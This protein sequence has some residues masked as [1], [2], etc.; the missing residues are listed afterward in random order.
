MNP[1][2]VAAILTAAGA[3][4]RMGESKALLD[5]GELPLLQHQVEV[6]L[7]AG[8][9]D[10]VVVLGD[11]A[12][13]IEAAVR[14]PARVRRIRNSRVD[15]GRSESLR[16]GFEA[17]QDQPEAIL[18]V[19]VDQP[20]SGDVLSKLLAAFDPERE[21]FAQPSFSGL[22]SHPVLFAG[23]LLAELQRIDEATRGLRAVTRRHASERLDVTLEGVPSPEFNTPAEYRA[24]IA[25][26]PPGSRLL[27]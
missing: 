18:V 22:R 25:L 7:Q 19:A 27:P 6:L 23:R 21:S 2:G 24:A 10:I 1:E 16:L 9:G 4:T 17:L 8:L 15:R 12:P 20:L 11:E 3:S 14:W 5:W 13:R 26:V